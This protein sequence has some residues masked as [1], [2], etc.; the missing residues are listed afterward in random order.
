MSQ[1][2]TR[3]I[4]AAGMVGAGAGFSQ[5]ERL[6]RSVEQMGGLGIVTYVGILA[7]AIVIGSW[8]T[9]RHRWQVYRV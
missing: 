8:R 1:A 4:L 2:V 6:L 7:I 9:Q 5:S 3:V